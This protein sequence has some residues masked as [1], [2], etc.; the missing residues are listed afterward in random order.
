MTGFK[1]R[2]GGMRRAP[3]L[4]VDLEG[5]LVGRVAHPVRLVDLSAVGVLLR[6][7]A[8][9]EP[10]AILDLHLTLRGEPFVAK[11]R[12]ID[13]SVDGTA[14]PEGAPRALVALEFARVAAQDQNRL[15][16]FL[17]DERRRRRSAD[18]PAE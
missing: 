17:E 3:R 1:A 5:S 11:V 18:A 10:G 8:L 14:V 12:V 9:L 16:G 4:S 13:S 15:R 2:S 6:C 7:D